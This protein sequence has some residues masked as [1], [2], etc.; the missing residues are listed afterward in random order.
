MRV[1]RDIAMMVTVFLTLI[2][3]TACATASAQ[4]VGVIGTGVPKGSGTPGLLTTA[5][6]SCEGKFRIVGPQGSAGTYTP[7]STGGVHS[8]MRYDSG[9]GKRHYF[10]IIPSTHV[11]ESVEPTLSPC[12]TAIG[13]TNIAGPAS[14]GLGPSGDVT[15]GSDWGPPPFASS[16][17]ND[18]LPGDPT[19][20]VKY[21]NIRW[22]AQT[23]KML[24]FWLETY[25]GTGNLGKPTF[26]ATTMNFTTHTFDAY[27]CWATNP[28]Q[29]DAQAGTGAIFPPASWVSANSALLPAGSNFWIIGTGGPGIYNPLTSNGPSL[30]LEPAPLVGNACASGVS[31][32]IGAGT[33]LS[34]YQANSAGPTCLTL[35][36]TPTTP[37]THPYP[38][39]T[40]FTGYSST[41][42]DSDWN[43]YGG[44]GYFFSGSY[45]GLD[46]YDDGTYHGIFL[47][48]TTVSGWG[49]GTVRAS[50]SPTYDAGTGIG[51]FS[52]DSIDTNDGFTVNP[53]DNFWV[54][55]CTVGVD[56]GCED[57]NANALTAGYVISVTGSGPYTITYN[58]LNGL[59]PSSGDHVPRVGGAWYFGPQ[60]GHG[61]TIGGY[62]RFMLRAQII[63]PAE[64]VKVLNGTYATSDLPTYAEDIDAAGLFPGLG[65]PSVGQGLNAG[66]GG[67]NFQFPFV[68]VAD[69]AHNRIIVDFP[70]EQN[71]P[72]FYFCST[73]YVLKVQ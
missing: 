72:A 27:G 48:F 69:S 62:P 25:G 3:T 17:T 10:T 26:G 46:W 14:W 42:Y 9:D 38:A 29:L 16:V 47:P 64:Y 56:A 49:G 43:P 54:T 36:C 59:D 35:G 55:T 40:S 44:T 20:F 22:D 50:P 5:N 6:I 12:G 58:S 4:S 18:G 30:I 32:P 11:W 41:Q 45:F 52:V 28:N 71:C 2:L 53:L 51:T 67:N 7:G 33:V 57:A 61:N 34:N 37:P 13:S 8:T 23:N 65:N 66:N 73:V 63:D 21:A 31:Y 1:V 60:Y 39:R 68:V 24:M 19:A 15:Y 70:N